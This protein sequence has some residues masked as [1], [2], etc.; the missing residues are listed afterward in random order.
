MRKIDDNI[1][2]ALNEKLPTDS[3]LKEE[4]N[5]SNKLKN[6]CSFVYTQLMDSYTNREKLIKG[7]ISHTNEKVIELKKLKDDNEN[8]PAFI[9]KLRSEQSQVC[10]Q[11]VISTIRS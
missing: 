6:E 11:L 3:F 1:I 2:Y 9:K 4:K 5:P 8:N 10:N 7:C